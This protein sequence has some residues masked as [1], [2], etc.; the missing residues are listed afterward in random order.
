VPCSVWN[1]VDP[2]AFASGRAV[3]GCG[4]GAVSPSSALPGRVGWPALLE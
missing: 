2:P 4:A 1:I 3:V